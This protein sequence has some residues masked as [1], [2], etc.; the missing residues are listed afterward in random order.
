M[1]DQLRPYRPKDTN[2]LAKYIMELST[3]ERVEKS[4]KVPAKKTKS[5]HKYVCF[6]ELPQDQQDAWNA[7]IA[8]SISSA[9]CEGDKFTPNYAD[10]EAFYGWWTEGTPVMRGWFKA[11]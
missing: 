10:Y 11:Q 9:I 8:F 2:Q 1:K 4:G 3:G 6:D 7:V 5:G